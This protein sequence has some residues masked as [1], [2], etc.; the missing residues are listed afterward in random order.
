MRIE[1]VF[2]LILPRLDTPA[3]RMIVVTL[4]LGETELDSKHDGNTIRVVHRI[5]E[6]KFGHLLMLRQEIFETAKQ[7][8]HAS[9]G[10]KMAMA[11]MR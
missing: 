2:E 9:E 8:S 4:L 7:E 10:S 6:F 11:G 5:I 1:E 3:C